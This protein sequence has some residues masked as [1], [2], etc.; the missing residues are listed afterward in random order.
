MVS[1]VSRNRQALTERP[2]RSH[3]LLV[4]SHPERTEGT[5]YAGLSPASLMDRPYGRVADLVGA[6]T[7][8]KIPRMSQRSRHC[9]TRGDGSHGDRSSGVGRASARTAAG[10]PC[11]LQTYVHTSVGK[12][13]SLR[14]GLECQVSVSRL[15]F[16]FADATKLFDGVLLRILLSK[17]RVARS[18]AR[19]DL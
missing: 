6:R 10:R 17:W 16:L 14:F 9:A 3:S 18:V 8:Q 13:Q 1:S 5:L 19:F 11:G 12:R 7:P 4:I 15:Q 2:A